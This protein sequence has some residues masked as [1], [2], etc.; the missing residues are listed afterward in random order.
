MINMMR[1]S[2]KVV[3]RVGSGCE[4]ASGPSAKPRQARARTR[5]PEHRDDVFE[6]ARVT[7]ARAR[8]D[9]LQDVLREHGVRVGTG[10]G[11]LFISDKRLREEDL[12]NAGFLKVLI[13]VPETGQTYFQTYRHPDLLLHFHRHPGGWT[14]HEDRHPSSTMLMLR[15]R[16]FGKVMAFLRGLPHLLME[17]VPGMLSYLRGLWRG[18]TD[19]ASRVRRE[20]TPAGSRAIS[21][22]S[23]PIVSEPGRKA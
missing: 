22:T 14:V 15:A 23:L 9:Q 11:R 6:P 17:G 12:V 21:R 3:G 7:N 18:S 2:P 5:P 8:I 1:V 19:T 20:T 10:H 16:G 4:V 13:A